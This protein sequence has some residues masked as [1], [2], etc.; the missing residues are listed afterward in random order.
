METIKR[1]LII[2]TSLILIISC[3]DENCGCTGEPIDQMKSKEVL[4]R[5]NSQIPTIGTEN[6]TLYTI[7]NKEIIPKRLLDSLYSIPVSN[8]KIIID[9]D[10]YQECVSGRRVLGPYARIKTIQIPK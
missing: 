6:Y 8:V 9:A 7:C 10:L 4:L 5:N 1:M 3:K 2:G